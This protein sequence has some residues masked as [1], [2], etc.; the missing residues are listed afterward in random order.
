MD[1]DSEE[2]NSSIESGDGGLAGGGISDSDDVGDDLLSDVDEDEDDSDGDLDVSDEDDEDD[3]EE[4]SEN[5]DSDEYVGVDRVQAIENAGSDDDGNRSSDI[6]E[7]DRLPSD[8][9]WGKKKSMYFGTDYI[10]KDFRRT[11]QQEEELAQAEEDEAKAIQ[12]RLLEEI[13]ETDLELHRIQKHQ[14]NLDSQGSLHKIAFDLESLTKKERIDLLKKES[15]ELI[16]LIEDFKSSLAEIER[17]KQ[18]LNYTNV[19]DLDAFRSTSAVKLF[20]TKFYL[21]TRYCINISYYL[22]LKSS[23]KPVHNHPVLSSLVAFKKMMLQID[24]L[25]KKKALRDQISQFKARISQ[26]ETISLQHTKSPDNQEDIEIDLR[27]VDQTSDL[28]DRPRKKKIRFADE[29]PTPT[30]GDQEIFRDYGDLREQEDESDLDDEDLDDD[31]DDDNPLERDAKDMEE[32]MGDM[33][34]DGKEGSRRPI[35]YQIAKNK[36]LTP[37]KKKE[38]RNPRVKH[39]KKFKKAKSNRRGQVREPRK[40]MRR[41]AG[42]TTGIKSSSVRSIRFK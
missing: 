39:R 21:L 35:N 6:E 27:D 11:R 38:L 36:G 31:D 2:D 10:D 9:A 32:E 15:P 8:K 16:G 26:N 24:A 1:S 13:D 25:E 4:G 34:S 41:Y 28:D 7:E 23:G 5:E 40:E 20:Q 19:D 18:M 12:K 33:D 42:E 30:E 14:E 29:Q 3:D 22:L 37:S 17:T